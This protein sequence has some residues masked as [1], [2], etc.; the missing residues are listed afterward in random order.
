M[1]DLTDDLFSSTRTHYAAG[2]FPTPASVLTEQTLEHLK[3]K[4]RNI[5]GPGVCSAQAEA[6]LRQAWSET[7]MARPWNLQYTPA[8]ADLRLAWSDTGK[9]LDYAVVHL[10]VHT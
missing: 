8:G 6:D 4:Q 7:G 9:A 1:G 3:P 2:R 10:L 5:R